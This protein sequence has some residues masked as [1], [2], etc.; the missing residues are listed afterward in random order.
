MRKEKVILHGEKVQVSNL[1]KIFFNIFRVWRTNRKSDWCNEWLYRCFCSNVMDV[2][3]SAEMKTVNV[4][5]YPQHI[6]RWF[7]TDCQEVKQE[8]RKC[9]R[10]FRK[11]ETNTEHI[12]AYWWWL[13]LAYESF[14]QRFELNQPP[15]AL[16]FKLEIRI[17]QL[18]FLSQDLSTAA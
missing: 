10:Y 7:D 2:L 8:L 3:L 15:P 9:I 13:F 12:E 18:H 6:A 16:L 14:G 11:S 17:H 4:G 5:S 1:K